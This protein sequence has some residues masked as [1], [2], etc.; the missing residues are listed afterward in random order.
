MTRLTVPPDAAG[1]RLDVWLSRRLPELS[2]AR[3]QALI[4]AGLITIRGG[5]VKPR[6]RLTAGTEVA[7]VVPPP[8]PTDLVP[9]PIPLDVLFEDDDLIVVNKPPG[10]VAHPAAG[11]ASGTL[12]NALVHRFRDLGGV[13]AAGRPGLVHRL[14]RDTS[15]VMVVARSE[16]ALRTLVT[17]FRGRAVRKE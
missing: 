16:R 7:V 13:G 12:A 3:I 15:G 11:H 1:V 14:D 17:L 10:L 6:T 9:E 8:P 2:R 5:R 4:R